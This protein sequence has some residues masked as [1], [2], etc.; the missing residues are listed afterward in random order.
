MKIALKVI[1]TSV[2]E[3]YVSFSYF[4]ILVV[5]FL[6]Y[7]M[8]ILKE[9]P[10]G[11]D[12]KSLF[13]SNF[14]ETDL[15][16]LFVNLFTLYSL[17]ETEIVLG[18]KQ[19]F[20][21]MMMSIILNTVLDY[22]LHKINPSL[23]CSTNVSAVLFSLIIWNLLITG[24]VSFLIVIT[25]GLIMTMVTLRESTTSFLNHS[26]GAL[27]GIVLA[28]VYKKLLPKKRQKLIKNLF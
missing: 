22:E 18:S 11:N 8:K 6:L 23:G 16:T 9:K 24:K 15:S 10:C 4:V 14:V 2:K 17:T 26:I 5:V 13:Y 25:L 21:L 27:T 28:V 3:V 12:L 20:V 7:M 1:P 19:F